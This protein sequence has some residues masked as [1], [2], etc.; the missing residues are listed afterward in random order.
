MR[1][2]EIEQ[3]HRA[4]AQQVPLSTPSDHRATRLSLLPAVRS[5][6]CNAISGVG[7]TALGVPRIGR[8]DAVRARRL[9]RRARPRHATTRER[10]RRS[11]DAHRP[12][13]HR[14]HP[15]A[16]GAG[17]PGSTRAASR[18]IAC[19]TG[20]APRSGM[21]RR[22]RGGARRPRAGCGRLIGARVARHRAAR[23]QALLAGSDCYVR[24][25]GRN[26]NSPGAL[27]TPTAEYL[28]Y[29]YFI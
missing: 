25:G 28:I 3:E 8:S 27:N 6:I 17:P 2:K 16:A 15:S 14:D 11:A 12:A 19:A 13:R 22:R 21:P 9:T 23:G 24:S 18:A 10:R 20:A 29:L 5:A 4:A 1:A 7:A 26:N